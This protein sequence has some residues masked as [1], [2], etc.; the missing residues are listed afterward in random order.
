MTVSKTVEVSPGIKWAV[1]SDSIVDD[2]PS[3]VVPVADIEMLT[4]A[5]LA[6]LIRYA[7][8]AARSVGARFKA[9]YV[10]DQARFIKKRSDLLETFSH[11]TLVELQRYAGLH[12]EIDTAI[13]LLVAAEAESQTNAESRRVTQIKRAE[14]ASDYSDIFVAIGR[15]DGF[16]CASCGNATADLQID[17]IVPVSKGGSNDFDNLQLLCRRCNIVKGAKV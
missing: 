4:D 13:S 9:S 14:I 16:F 1:I 15:R 11:E 3:V 5:E 8:P 12:P 17:H 7:V 6:R 10:I 2:R